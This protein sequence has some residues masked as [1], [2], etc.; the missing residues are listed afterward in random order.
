MSDD[1]IY[2][3]NI[4]NDNNKRMFRL[5]VE[6][7]IKQLKDKKFILDLF[8]KSKYKEEYCKAF[9]EIFDDNIMNS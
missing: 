3:L 5:L 9:Y 1:D 4:L 6:I 7:Y 8:M 2:I